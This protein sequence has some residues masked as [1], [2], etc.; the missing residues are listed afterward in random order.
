MASSLR[1]GIESLPD[2][3]PAVLLTLCD[4][5]LVTAEQLTRLA[6]AWACDPERAAASAYDGTIGVPAILPKRLY[7]DLLALSGDAGAKSV[8]RQELS[9]LITLAIPEAA[10]DVDTEETARE[11]ARLSK[12][13]EKAR[14][15]LRYH[16]NANVKLT[17][18]SSPSAFFA[19]FC[20]VRILVDR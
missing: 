14:V 17:R 7:P 18:G 2:E 3:S 11:L 15:R 19:G 20:S 8:L 6:R 13:E 1:K 10:F 16:L 4:H 12:I 5:P 9:S